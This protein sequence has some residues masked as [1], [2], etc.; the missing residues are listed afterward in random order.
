[1]ARKERTM[2]KIHVRGDTL[3]VTIPAE[4]RDEIAVHD[5]EDIDISAEGGRIVLTPKEETTERHPAIDAAIAEGLADERAGRLSPAFETAE[6]IEAWQ[7]SEGFK[8]FIGKA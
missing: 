4:L 1:M 8:K 5:G 2:P 3:T 7:K 6:E